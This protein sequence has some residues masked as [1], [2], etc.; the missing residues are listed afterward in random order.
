MDED[1]SVFVGVDVEVDPD[2]YLE[3]Q[4]KIDREW[5]DMVE[6]GAA[7]DDHH[8]PFAAWEDSAAMKMNQE[9]E[10]KQKVT[11]FAKHEFTTHC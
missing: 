10:E 4:T 9:K 7:F 5:Y 6:E 3:E 2:E 11:L 8:N 1:E